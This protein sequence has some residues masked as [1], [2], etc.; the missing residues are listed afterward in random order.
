LNTDPNFTYEVIDPI[1]Y[2]A[3]SLQEQKSPIPIT[4]IEGEENKGEK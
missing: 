1:A 4:K 3:E 2:N